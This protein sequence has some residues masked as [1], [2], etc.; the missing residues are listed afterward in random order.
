MDPSAA[1][2]LLNQEARALLTRLDRLQPYALHM[3]MV[4]AAAVSPAAQAAIEA[5]TVRGRRRLRALVRGFLRWL[6][7]PGG[8]RAGPAEGQRRFTLLRLR[9]NN[10]IAQFDIFADVLAQRSEHETGVWVAGLD[11]VAADGLELPGYYRAPPVICY[12]DRGPGAA[13]RRARTRLPGGEAN[14]VAIIRVPRERMVGS[15]IASSLLHEVGHQAAALLDLVGSLRPALQ[16]VQR[17]HAGAER[18]AW[19]LWERWISEIVADLW[20]VARLG[21]GATLGLLAVVSL[22]RAFVFRADWEDPHPIPWVRVRLSA[23]LGQALYPHPQ[24]EAMARLWAA[25]YPPDGLSPPRR[26]LLGAL[27][28][29]L[30]DFVT[31][32]LGHR[33]PR[34]R[35]RS[36]REALADE[37][38]RPE[39]LAAAYRAWGASPEGLRAAPPT[40]AFAVI[41]QA[42][43]D[44]RITPEEESHTLANLLTYWALRSALETSVTCARQPRQR[45]RAPAS[46]PATEPRMSLT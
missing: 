6:H 39:R 14:P 21:V 43:A 4:P 10:V 9:F 20:A 7:G 25:L 34:L 8:R 27:E 2:R 17:L 13:I 44:G 46:R 12:L 11:D 36:L 35:G 15:G 40:L 38:R 19:A 5:H 30:P 31:V 32:L 1:S 24:W 23:A 22:P 3:P 16:A 41:G 45:P 26:L 37:A 42:R 28:T 18:L 29:T 33:P